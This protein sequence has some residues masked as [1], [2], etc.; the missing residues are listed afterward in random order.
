MHIILLQPKLAVSAV[1]KLIDEFPQFLFLTPGVKSF[2]KLANEEW[3]RVEIIYGNHLAPDELAKAHQLRWIH[4]PT[5]NLNP[6]CLNE[7]EKKE[8][9]ILTATKEE[10]VVQIAEF[11]LAGMLGFA[12]QLFQW[13]EADRNPVMLLDSK[14]RE[15]M[16]TLQDRTFLQ[17]GLEEVGTEITRNCKLMGMKVWGVQEKESFHPYC[18]KVF[19]LEELRE[20]LPDSDVVCISWPRSKEIR[21]IWF[22]EKEFA[23]MKEGSILLIL[24]FRS[25]V[26]E[27]A[28]AMYASSGKFRGVLID[29]NY[30]L[31]LASTSRLWTI[32]NV[33]ITPEAAP[34]PKGVEKEPLQAF[35]YNLRQY[36]HGNFADMR[37]I[38]GE[39]RKIIAKFASL[40]EI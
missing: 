3:L 20:A 38:V 31:P 5:T 10:N 12:K 13:K 26:D 34:R 16:W 36:I 2:K 23:L 39:K 37:G 4:S 30:Q 14:L 9:I 25:F 8:N 24:G 7:I 28:L 32:P 21:K 29:E 27:E 35:Q 11:A 1:R 15:S 18:R 40:I 17:I 6:L 33:I 19:G 22:G